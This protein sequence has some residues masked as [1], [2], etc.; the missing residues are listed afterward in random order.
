MVTKVDVCENPSLFLYFLTVNTDAAEDYIHTIYTVYLLLLLPQ[1]P[2]AIR[3]PFAALF[4]F[5]SHLLYYYVVYERNVIK[6]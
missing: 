4:L 6:Y 1:L 3:G 2:V 5:F